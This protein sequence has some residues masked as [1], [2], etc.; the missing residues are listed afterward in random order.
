MLTATPPLF[1]IHG[2]R[3]IVLRSRK[4]KNGCVPVMMKFWVGIAFIHL[5]L[6]AKMSRV[7]S[8]WSSSWQ[9]G[10]LDES[11]NHGLGKLSGGRDLVE[12]IWLGH[13]DRW[14]R[15]RRL[16]WW[17]DPLLFPFCCSHLRVIHLDHRKRHKDERVDARGRQKGV[18]VFRWCISLI[19]C[20]KK[21]EKK[22]R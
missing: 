5:N 19:W 15:I 16:K 3:C 14:A 7:V 2:G 6:M 1:R 13:D 4:N 9:R 21:I 18:F 10:A 12:S 11:W 22:E 20:K 17:N 8:R